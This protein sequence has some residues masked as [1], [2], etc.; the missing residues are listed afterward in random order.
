VTVGERVP[1][2]WFALNQLLSS[3]LPTMRHIGIPDHNHVEGGSDP[4]NR[5]QRS[6]SDCNITG[7]RSGDRTPGS[8]HGEALRGRL[9]G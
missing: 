2:A 1:L 6:S 5:G 4:P 7:I 8:R 9:P 3:H